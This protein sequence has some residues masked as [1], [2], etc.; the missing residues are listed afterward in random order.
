MVK[1]LVENGADVNVLSND[2]SSPLLNAVSL[3]R[4]DVVAVTGARYL[5]MVLMPIS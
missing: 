2:G 1:F 3:G 5:R 4:K